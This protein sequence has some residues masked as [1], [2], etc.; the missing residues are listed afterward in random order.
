MVLDKGI[1]N[2]ISLTCYKVSRGKE[3][4]PKLNK[5]LKARNIEQVFKDRLAQDEEMLQKFTEELKGTY[6][7]DQFSH[8]EEVK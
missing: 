1:N 6:Y 7:S 8:Y 5:S 3:K 4:M 2:M